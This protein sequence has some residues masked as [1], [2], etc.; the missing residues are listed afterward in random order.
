MTTD[1][2][3][4]FDRRLDR[5][6][7]VLILSISLGILFLHSGRGALSFAAGGILSFIN[8]RWLKGAVDFAVR[9]VGEEASGKR[10]AFRYAARYVLIGLC[11]YVTL[12]Y[13]VLDT[14][15]V[16]SGLLVYVGAMLLEAILEISKTLI[17]D[18]RNGR[19]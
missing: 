10:I 8:F 4:M 6:T 1:S 15:F 19:T 13:S 2:D 9:S 12:R 16:L 14:V 17:R 18:Q 7:A 3:L 11:L 5:T